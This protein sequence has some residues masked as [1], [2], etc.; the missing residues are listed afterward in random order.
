VRFL[1]LEHHFAQDV[2][3]LREAASGEVELDVIHYE[4]LRS[5]AL[6]VLP[7]EVADGLRAFAE[8]ELAGARRRY[9]AI[10]REIL[11]D[12]FTRAAFDA[13]VVPSDTFFYVRCAPAVAHALGVP[14]LVAQKETT[15]SEHTMREHAAEVRRFSP[16]LA[17]RMTVCSERHKRFWVRAGGDPRRIV[18]TG[19]PRFDF[20]SRP[21]AWPADV[22]LGEGGPSVLFLSYSVD[23]YHP[24]EGRGSS[25]WS[26]LHRQTERGL[27]ELARRGWLVLVKPHPQQPLEMLERW[28]REAAELWGRRVFAVDPQ[29]D[30]RPLIVAADA[31]VGFQ[32]TAL[33][34]AMVAGR[35]VIYTAWDPAAVALEGRLIPFQRW[36]REIV[37]VR[38]AE[39][40]PGAVVSAA[41]RPPSADLL[42]A[43]R[44]I[45]ERYLGPLDGFAAQ[46]TMA[47]LREEASLW[48]ARRGAPERELRAR[49][50]A[51]KAPLRLARRGR[52]W[53]RTAK[54]R[55]GAT[56]RR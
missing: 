27:C 12:R 5:E 26:A 52:D 33:L 6:R 48:A 35:P 1:L 53:A 54:R 10:L 29:A 32:S 46:R 21:G 15:I 42:R 4:L 49:L 11:E 25:A 55:V 3:A 24:S 51:R 43:R 16:P 2:D 31:V 14:F 37:S 13:L 40:L 50:I 18:V 34:E 22:G 44:E 8:P 28:R 20:Y 30:V 9:A 23:A 45:A 41:N 7:P 47:A 38:R 17:D 56:L 19:Q 39:E 36:E